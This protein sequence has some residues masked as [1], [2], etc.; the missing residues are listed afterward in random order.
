MCSATAADRARPQSSLWKPPRLPKAARLSG[1]QALL[2]SSAESTGD[3][4]RQ[5]IGACRPPRPEHHKA[6]KPG[7]ETGRKGL[8][9]LPRY[10]KALTLGAPELPDCA[11]IYNKRKSN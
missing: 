1:A 9:T 6:K 10:Y 2:T 4:H 8:R 11:N 7:S 5:R 3:Q